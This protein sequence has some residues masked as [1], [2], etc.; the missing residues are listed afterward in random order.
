MGMSGAQVDGGGDPRASVS[1]MEDEHLGV[2][3]KGRGSFIESVLGVLKDFYETTAQGLR[4]WAPAAPKV[5]PVPEETDAE[6]QEQGV[7]ASL[8][9]TAASSQDGPATE[10][11]RP[12][13]KVDHSPSPTSTGVGG[14]L[15]WPSSPSQH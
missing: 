14:P 3:G 10:S 2:R 11:E 1:E 6:A 15:A 9:S 12:V 13:E 8:V 5:R 4:P 7:A